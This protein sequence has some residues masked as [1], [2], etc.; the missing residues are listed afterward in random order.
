LKI[1]KGF[2]ALRKIWR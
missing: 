2:V 1:N